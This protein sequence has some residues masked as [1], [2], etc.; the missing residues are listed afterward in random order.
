LRGLND[1][2]ADAA[3]NVYWS[4]PA[5][6]SGKNPTGRVYRV[7][8]SGAVEML[9]NDL[10]FPNGIE[11]DPSNRNLYV[12]ESQT[13][14]VLRYDLPAAGQKLGAKKVFFDFGQDSAGGDGLCFDAKGNAWMAEF[15]NKSGAGRVVVVSPAGKL[16]GEIKPAAKLITNIAFGGEAN[17]EIF[18]STGAPSGVFRAKVGSQGFRG[19]PVPQVKTIRLLKLSPLNEAIS[20]VP[21]RPR[22]AELRIEHA[23]ESK[24]T[25][26][27]LERL[28][29]GGWELLR[30]HGLNPLACWVSVEGNAKNAVVV[31]L[32][33]PPSE[34]AAREGWSNL[35]V[36]AAFKAL[37][38]QSEATH[39]KIVERIEILKLTAPA[40]AWK[41]NPNSNRPKRVFDL[42]LYS[43][44]PEKEIIFRDRWR[45]HAIRLYERHGMDNLGWWE[46]TD[47]E[48][49]GVMATLF[50]HESSEAINR[51]IAAFHKDEDWIRVEKET[52]SN[53][54]L[55]STAAA[56]R[57]VPARFSPLR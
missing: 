39:G 3:G 45:D 46:A 9:A 18:I 5:D 25:A 6:S 1:V 30:K 26:A 38:A 2:T 13:R 31:L 24:G 53:G 35:I 33:A 20:V 27:I 43:R 55:R 14:K 32:L 19:H 23:A 52:E 37:K 22:Y 51:V 29:S 16:L 10:A 48:H 36:D 34:A 7:T 57:L 21:N 12:I 40:D 11:V 41:L 28:E 4:D 8:P 49:R 50:A 17:D 44:L 54:K 47:P 15:N 56:Y 42:R